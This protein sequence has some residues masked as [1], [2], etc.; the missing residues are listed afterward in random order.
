MIL[1]LE[2]PKVKKLGSDLYE[3]KVKIRNNGKFPYATA[4]GQ[5]TTHISS[6]MLRMKFEDDDKMKLFGGTKRMDTPTL[7]AGAEKEFR[8]IIISPTGK[9]I[10]V[11]LWTP[12]GGG[13]VKKSVVLK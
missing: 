9:K 4:M 7:N 5:R 8:W 2:E 11:A 12:N 3:L 6:I 1:N 10:D 13:T